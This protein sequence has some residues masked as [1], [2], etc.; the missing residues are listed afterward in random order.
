MGT[1][2]RRRCT[3]WIKYYLWI[4]R[5][6][7]QRRGTDNPI[8]KAR[9]LAHGCRDAEKHNLVQ[10]S[11]NVRQSHVRLLIAFAAIMEFDV[12]TEDI[13]QAYLQSASKLLRE[14]Y[15]RPNKPLQSPTGYTLK[16]LRPLCELAGSGD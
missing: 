7:Y 5:H 15:R 12:W 8:F 4:F 10:G 1:R 11:I 6:C 13:S 16:L 9:F 3:T 14:V 2:S